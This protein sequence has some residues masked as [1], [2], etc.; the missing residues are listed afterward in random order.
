MLQYNRIYKVEVGAPGSTSTVLDGIRIEFTSRK[1]EDT[2]PNDL[3]L[4]LY[5][6]SQNSRVAFETTDNQVIL[7]VGYESTGLQLLAIGD[8]VTGE[9]EFK[10][11]EVITRVSCRDGGRALRDA[12]SS[13]S[14]EAGVSAQTILDR[15]IEKL[16]V[17]NIQIDT[18]LSGTFPFGWSYFGNVR[19]GIDKLARR[20]NFNW[21]IQN[22]TLQIAE[23]RKP[24]GRQAVLLS[25][26]S[27][28][29]G[30]PTRVDKVKSNRTDAKEEPGLRVECLL[31]PALIPG[32]PVIIESRQYPRGYYRITSVDHNG[33][34]HGDPWTTTIEAV[35][36]R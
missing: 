5:N 31:N 8:I 3:D 9:T 2:E 25:P 4:T 19:E 28:M 23:T 16:N 17:D 20:F 12:R 35:E 15:L 33:D 26:Q 22:N 11:P 34:T 30:S 27:G 6:L 21:S 24:T 10:S 1:D 29:V 32:D 18:D 13:E 14:F 36:I 7:H